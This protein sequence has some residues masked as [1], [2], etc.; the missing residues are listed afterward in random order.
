MK[1]KIIITG[2]VVVITTFISS[3]NAVLISFFPGLDELIQKADAIVILRVDRQLTDFYSST[4]YS[5][6]DCYIY[7]TLKGNIPARTI[8]RLQL[9]DT[10]TSQVP[11]YAFHS[12]HLMFLTK[13][14][15]ADEPTDYRT[16]EIRGANIL[17]SPFGHEKDLEGKTTRE[18][19]ISLLKTT[20]EYNKKQYEK[21]Q[22]F[23]S[24]MISGTAEPDATPNAPPM[25]R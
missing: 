11:T 2:L 15:T 1:N 19:I 24:Q 21:E 23:L 6:H 16:I 4:L 7:Q 9:M 17:L 8:V 13:K 5:T 10:R 18:K 25:H 14:R 12:T 20:V 22:T 3:V